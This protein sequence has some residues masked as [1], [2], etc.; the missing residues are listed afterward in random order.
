[1]ERMV[2]GRSIFY[3]CFKTS[4]YTFLIQDGFIDY[5]TFL[6]VIRKGGGRRKGIEYRRREGEQGI[7]KEDWGREPIKGGHEDWGYNKGGRTMD[8]GREVGGKLH[9]MGKVGR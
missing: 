2:G 5:C 8:E 4:L 6:K 1:M 9:G 3:I 7:L